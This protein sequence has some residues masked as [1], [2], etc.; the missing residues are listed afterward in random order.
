MSNNIPL[1]CLESFGAS[2]THKLNVTRDR[3][4]QHGNTSG[5]TS[6]PSCWTQ[7]VKCS[8]DSST[9][10]DSAAFFRF[11]LNGCC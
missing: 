5:A 11:V 7:M 3:S 2:H 4:A 8:D 10:F 9:E 1:L 6:A